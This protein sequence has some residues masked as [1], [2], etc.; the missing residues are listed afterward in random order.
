[1]FNQILYTNNVLDGFINGE[2][3]MKLIVGLGNPEGK[4]T[5]T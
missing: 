3:Y 5:N 2:F 4:Y 1:M